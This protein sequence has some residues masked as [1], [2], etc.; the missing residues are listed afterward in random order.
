[1]CCEEIT[2]NNNNKRITY[3][4]ISILTT[5]IPHNKSNKSFFNF[6]LR[7]YDVFIEQTWIWQ[8][9]S[10]YKCNPNIRIQKWLQENSK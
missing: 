10:I 1:M 2:N 8:Y 5:I 9:P 6:S 4:N 7:N 3:L